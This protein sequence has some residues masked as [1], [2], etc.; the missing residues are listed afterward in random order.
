MFSSPVVSVLLAWVD[1][2]VVVSLLVFSFSVFFLC[3]RSFPC[4][5][6]RWWFVCWFGGQGFVFSS[7]LKVPP[8]QPMWS[9]KSVSCSFLGRCGVRMSRMASVRLKKPSLSVSCSFLGRC[10]MRISRMASVRFRKPRLCFTAWAGM[11]TTIPWVSLPAS[12]RSMRHTYITTFSTATTYILL[13]SQVPVLSSM[14]EWAD[15][16]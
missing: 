2:V 14:H 4:F 5:C 7:P 3:F 8:R 1:S 16:S 15:V 12:R 6:F 10:G 11:P 9:W 13:I